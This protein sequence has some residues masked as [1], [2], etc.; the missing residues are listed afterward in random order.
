[1][2]AAEHQV[3]TEFL[4]ISPDSRLDAVRRQL[5]QL[6]N[7]RIALVV[8]EGW[9]DLNNV[10]RM[11][12]MQRQAQVQQCD[13]ALVTRDAE[14][15]KAAHTLGIP[16]FYTNEA[17]LQRDWSMYPALPFVDPRQPDA[18]LP[19]PP[20]WRRADIVE[21]ET[22]PS[23]HRARQERIAA[24]ERARRP[25]PR[26]MNWAGYALVSGLLI[27]VLGLFTLYVLPA[28]TVTV[29]PGRQQISVTTQLIANPDLEESD[30]DA[31]QIKGR[32]IETT[33][34]DT[35]SAATSGSLQKPTIKATGFATFSNLGNAEVRVP[36]GTT[37][38]S[39][40]GTPISFRTT[41]DAFIPGGV[42][43]R[44]SVAIEALEPGVEGNVRANTI[45]NI[46]G[47]LRFR[48]RVSN[49]GGTDGG[50]SELVRAVTQADK[51]RLLEETLARAEARAVQAL[52]EKLQPGEW[53]PPESVKTF[54][55]AQAF[56]QYNDDEAD[57]VDLT[58]RVLVQ[59]IAIGEDELRDV[60][61]VAVEKQ[62]PAQARLVANSLKAE[63]LPGAVSVGRGV[64]FTATVNAKYLTPVD[65]VEVRSAV[66]GLS[67]EEASALLQ[68]RW[69]L[70]SEPE[71]YRD[72]QWLGSLP[73]LPSRIQ[74][75]VLYDE[76]TS[77]AP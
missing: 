56:D 8:P 72:P 12:L 51:D 77:S 42:G 41:S 2:G 24:E 15:I 44:V 19:D 27:V 3:I 23:H 74:V 43:Q 25:L 21:R 63:S 76:P 20:A 17:A 49:P 30:L 13:L 70:E 34:E 4:T 71:F 31:N 28:A 37:I 46:D 36:L 33:I 18:A 45:T 40:T 11:R 61:Q 7:R 50:G 65:A 73:A 53:L 68:S 47:P 62:V 38:S 48:V 58:L 75:R 67:E 29:T 26:W 10:A 59:G 32:L 52:Q 55:V 9:E 54:V 69:L 57:Q 39:S 66:A 14:A 5:A 22:R 16:I 6:H 64:E 35:G 1:L 60:L